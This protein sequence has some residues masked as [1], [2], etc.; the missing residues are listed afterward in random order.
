MAKDTAA[1]RHEVDRP[2]LVELAV[3]LVA[4][5][6]NPSILNPD[7]L[8]FN[9]I[10][11]EGWDVAQSPVSTPAFSQVV[12]KN[13]VT[14]TADPGRVIFT[15]NDS[16]DENLEPPE[17]AQRYL[18]Q[19]PHAPYSAV[20]INPKFFVRLTS[21]APLIKRV[22]RNQGSWTPFKDVTPAVNLKLVYAYSGRTILL[23]VADAKLTEEDGER[24]SGRLFQANVH[25]DV[26]DSNAHSRNEKISAILD[27]WEDDRKDVCALIQKFRRGE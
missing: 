26:T 7:F 8:R 20:G 23:D 6:N 17:I 10:V 4:R 18:Q 24:F 2:A 21:D 9:G 5:S 19:V 12:F 1:E 25:R 3:V 14:V 27:G 15:A 11:S 13:G 22:L 16:T